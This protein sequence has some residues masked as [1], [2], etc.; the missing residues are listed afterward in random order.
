MWLFLWEIGENGKVP[1]TEEIELLGMMAEITKKD[2]LQI[3][4]SQGKI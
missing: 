2:K 3:R 4:A 1:V